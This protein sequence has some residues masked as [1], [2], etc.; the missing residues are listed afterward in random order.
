MGDKEQ[1][2]VSIIPSDALNQKV[3]WLNSKP[4]VASVTESGVVTALEPGETIIT[5]KTEDGDFHDQCAVYVYD[6]T[7]GVNMQ[8]SLTMRVGDKYTI[9]AATLPLGTSDGL[10]Y[11]KSDDNEIATIDETGL[12]KAKSKGT[13]NLSQHC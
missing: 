12:V 11:F 10:I 8:T 9:N 1:I 2:T 3:S 4:E 5:V 13:C 7:T 6:H